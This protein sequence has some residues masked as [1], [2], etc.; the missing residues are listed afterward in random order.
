MNK[1]L[2][3]SN[4]HLT[5]SILIVTTVAFVYGFKPNLWFDVKLITIDEFNIYKAIMGLYIA[6]SSLWFIGITT[7]K[8]WQTA[9]ISNFL[10]MFGLAIGRIISLLFDGIPSTLFLLGTI[11]ELI[12]GFYAFYQFKNQ[13][14]K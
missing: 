6:F 11:G 12:L 4:L 1:F 10:F 3:P 5:I 9:T 8:L 7:E 13:K 2:K 14:I